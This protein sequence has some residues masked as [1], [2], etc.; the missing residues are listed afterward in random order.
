MANGRRKNIHTRLAA[1]EHRAGEA[2]KRAG[3]RVVVYLSRKDGD[4]RPVGIIAQTGAV[5]MVRYDC[6]Q[7]D[8]PLP[9]GW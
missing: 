9:D 2:R 5:L 3:R 7:P 8:P 6:A 4:T 1:L